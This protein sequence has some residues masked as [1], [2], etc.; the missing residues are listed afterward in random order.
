MTSF[1]STPVWLR[2]FTKLVA[3]STLFLIFAGAMVTSHDAGLSVP[4]WP[5]TYGQFMFSFPISKWVGGI[6]YEHSHRL[7][8]STVGFLTVVQALWLWRR[9]PKRRVRILGW[10]AV[11]AVVA[12]GILGGLTV[13]FLLPPAISV[14]HAALAEIFFCLNVTIAVMTSRWW[15]EHHQGVRSAI[16]RAL[17]FIIYAQ[18]LIGAVMRHLNAGLAIPDFPLSFGKVIPPFTSAAIAINYAHR[19]GAV[20]VAIAIITVAARLFAM[21]ALRTNAILLVA[22]VIAQICL[23]AMTV[24]SG[25]EPLITS[26]HVMTGAATL[27]LSLITALAATRAETERAGAFVASEVLA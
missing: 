17:P 24:W 4:D 3:V 18:I 6:F 21:R 8:A 11:G 25:K 19:A 20:V 23:G 1:E 27:A 22:A 2:R 7:I 16:V 10:C 13:L 15:S 12:Q 14:G 9:E 26:L 5:N